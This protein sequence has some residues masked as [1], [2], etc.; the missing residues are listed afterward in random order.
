[1]IDRGTYFELPFKLR[2]VSDVRTDVD[3]VIAISGAGGEQVIVRLEEFQL[4]SP[5]GQATFDKNA[6]VS[7]TSLELAGA[8]VEAIRAMKDGQLE[9]VLGDGHTIGAAPDLEFEA[10]VVSAT[11]GITVV[12]GPGHA[13]SIFDGP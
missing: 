1:M 8:S 3:I 4:I 9:I 11:G 6:L 10:W 7:S 12:G 5:A 13:V 2:L